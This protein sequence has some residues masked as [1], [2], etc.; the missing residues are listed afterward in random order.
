MEPGSPRPIHPWSIVNTRELTQ[1]ANG[2][3]AQLLGLNDGC[4]IYNDPCQ[5]SAGNGGEKRKPD[6]LYA[7]TSRA[8]CLRWQE[9]TTQSLV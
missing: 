3:N 6:N 2:G 7:A 8:L 5:K 4:I 1:R 9:R